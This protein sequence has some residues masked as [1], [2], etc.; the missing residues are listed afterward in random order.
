MDIDKD[1]DRTFPQFS[2][3]REGAGRAQLRNVLL[4]Y[5]V[6]KPNVGYC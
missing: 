5:S 6:Y 4:A 2:F 1:V 3:F